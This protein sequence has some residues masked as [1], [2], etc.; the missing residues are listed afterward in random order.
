MNELLALLK[1]VIAGTDLEFYSD[2]QIEQALN[3]AYSDVERK[4]GTDTDN[5]KYN[6]IEGAKWYLARIGVE[7]ETQHTENGVTRVY[8]SMENP[9]WLANIIPKVTVRI[10]GAT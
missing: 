4:V 8:A 5:Y 1:A 10:N 7:G 9:A 2:A 3:M 6:I